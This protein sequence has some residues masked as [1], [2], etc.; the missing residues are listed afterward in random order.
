MAQRRDSSRV[1][2]TNIGAISR[3]TNVMGAAHTL[4]GLHIK[5]VKSYV[6]NAI[7]KEGLRWLE[8]GVNTP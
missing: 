3:L 8:I 6:V 5:S 2:T 7:L 1:I 4:M